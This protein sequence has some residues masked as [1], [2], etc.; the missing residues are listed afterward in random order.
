VREARV[1][2]RTADEGKAIASA[3]LPVENGVAEL[4]RIELPPL[5]GRYTAEFALAGETTWVLSHTFEREAYPWEGNT[6][7]MT[8]EVFA[9]FTPVQAGDDGTV[10]VVQRTYQLDGLGLMSSLVALGDELLAGPM[11]V[12]VE[13]ANGHVRELEP[14]EITLQSATDAAA[15]YEGQASG[16]GL[17]IA[18]TVTVE[19]DGMVKHE[20]VLRP[21]GKPVQVKRLWLDIPLKQDATPLMHQTTDANRIHYTGYVPQGDGVVWTSTDARRYAD[22]QNTFNTYL[23]L[24]AEGPG[25]AWFAEND[26]DWLTERGGS[27]KPIQQVIREAGV[28]R[29]EVM[30]ANKPSTIE[31]AHRIVFGLQASP[32][33]PR[34]EDWRSVDPPPPPMSGPVNPWGGIQCAAKFPYQDDWSVVEKV[35][36]ARE[37]GEVDF[38]WFEQWAEDNN[39]PLVHGRIPWVK[40]TT[41]FAKRESQLPQDY[42]ALIYF[43]EM[44]ASPLRPEWQTFQDQWGT[45]SFTDRTWPDESVMRQG[46]NASPNAPTGFTRS[47]QDYGLWYA[48]EWL[49]RGI[50]LYWDNTYPQ[51][52]FDPLTSEAYITE[53]GK[54]QPAMTLF[55]QRDYQKRIWNLMQQRRRTNPTPRP[56][57][58]SVHM[59]STL[60]L[61]L[62]TFATIQLDHEFSLAAPASPDYIRTE[63][64][65]TQAGNF[66]HALFPLSGSVN[67]A[68]VG[69]KPSHRDRLEWGMRRVHEVLPRIG[70]D[71][72]EAVFRGFGYGRDEVKAHQYW[73]DQ[74]VLTT[75]HDDTYWLALHDTQRD[76]WLIL[77]SSWDADRQAAEVSLDPAVFSGAFAFA[78]AETGEPIPADGPTAVTVP[79]T[80]PY[81][82]RMVVVHE[83]DTQPDIHWTRRTHEAI[84]EETAAPK[85]GDEVVGKG[86]NAVQKQAPTSTVPDDPRRGITE[87]A[88]VFADDF[89]DGFAQGWSA[90]QGAQVVTDEQGNHVARFTERRQRL[91]G[92]E[93]TPGNAD[94]WQDHAI[95]FRVRIGA[96]QGDETNR[97]PVATWVQMT[98]RSGQDEDTRWA[99]TAYLQMW[100]NNETWR[101]AGP[102]VA[103]D[104]RNTP[105]PRQNVSV[106]PHGGGKNILK[107]RVDTGWHEVEIRNVG[108]RTQVRFDDQVVFD[109]YD[110]RARTGQFML[111]ALWDERAVPEHVDID[112]LTVW[113]IDAIDTPADGPTMAALPVDEAPTIDGDLGDAAWWQARDAGLG[114]GDWVKFSGQVGDMVKLPYNRVAWLT[115]DDEYL[116]VAM[117][118]EAEDPL[119]LVAGRNGDPFHGD[120]LEIH[121]KVID[122]PY[123]Q[124]GMDVSNTMVAGGLHTG[125]PLTGVEHAAVYT[126]DGWAAELAIP[127]SVISVDPSDKPDL[128]INLAA[129]RASQ[130]AGSHMAI[131]ATPDVF[132][133]RQEGVTLQW[134][135]RDAQGEQAAT[136]RAKPTRTAPTI[137]GRLDE[138]AWAMAASPLAMTAV[139]QATQDQ[140][141]PRTVYLASDD[142]HLYVAVRTRIESADALVAQAATFESG[143]TLRLDFAEH[144]LGCDATG[145]ALQILLPYQIPFE[146]RGVI[147]D[148]LWTLELAV[149]WNQIGGKPAP[150]EPISF[151]VSGHDTRTGLVSWQ[152]VRN[153]R[154]TDQF[155]ELMIP[156]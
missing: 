84:A 138:T 22:W 142:E 28:H 2:I 34:P 76:Q 80:P 50:G 60:L 101:V 112:E 122:G 52:S 152:P 29:I 12:K 61:P 151:N 74:P 14:G 67:P 110:E 100:R 65:G 63:M 149:P 69:I 128:R 109:G 132:S 136:A 89:E 150:G 55:N 72:L 56:L 66:P 94:Q 117:R 54:V 148:G 134:A 123:L 5:R 120:G 141:R 3:T 45:Q 119:S 68:I 85:P 16:A 25:L 88:V 103:W 10:G 147:E 111:T 99:R 143:D 47:Y 90:T 77:L 105:F 70:G 118:A 98:W 146:A 43:E 44:R 79:L 155:G 102:Y 139:N 64:I 144:A 137:D 97:N 21:T 145:N 31:R 51:P 75:T 106:L 11:T 13:L 93:V 40:R 104:G 62:H 20:W 115:Y 36:E 95:R 71:A 121:M 15:V 1:T 41:Y 153:V 73:A 35:I 37:T 42:P 23:W 81:G 114:I 19:F 126:D 9:P 83:A 18:S 57:H 91:I 8:D 107:G 135:Q 58:W 27:D 154:D 78:D 96:H 6:L 33:K 4:K 59:T 116:Y 24:G 127:W 87:D 156:E 7:G 32:T 124:L 108:P 131:T 26:K 86:K 130:G 30:F 133:V 140:Q 53:D 46:F 38:D 49:K 113:S 39:P 92:P 82:T 17:T 125:Q 129:N 48:D